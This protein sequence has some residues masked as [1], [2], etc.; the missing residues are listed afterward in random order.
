MYDSV[1]AQKTQK[2][3]LLSNLKWPILILISSPLSFTPLVKDTIYL[4]KNTSDAFSF[5]SFFFLK[6]HLTVMI[7]IVQ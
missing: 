5:K 1:P 4:N 6:L 7:S 2:V 3:D